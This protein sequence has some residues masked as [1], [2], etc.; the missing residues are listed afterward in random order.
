MP[1]RRHV[2]SKPTAG[3]RAPT[4][5][6]LRA[7][8]AELIGIAAQHGASNVRVFGSVAR[9]DANSASDIDLLVELEPARSLFDL[10]GLC[11]DL[12]DA[13]G[14][15]VDVIELPSREASA[16]TRR[17]ADRILREAVPL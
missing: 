14:R 8:R 7:R 9:G 6:D 3:R 16:T 10:G 1:S 13:L 5:H 12:Q 15:K 17:I 4:L 2:V 11:E